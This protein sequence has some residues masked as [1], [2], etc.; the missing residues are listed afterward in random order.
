[1]SISSLFFLPHPWLSLSSSLLLSFETTAPLWVHCLL[2]NLIPHTVVAWRNWHWKSQYLPML[3]LKKT[4]FSQYLPA[5]RVKPWAKKRKQ[6]SHLLRALPKLYHRVTSFHNSTDLESICLFPVLQTTLV[7]GCLFAHSPQH[8]IYF[9]C[10]PWPLIHILPLDCTIQ[11]Y[12]QQT[13]ILTDYPSDSLTLFSLILLDILKLL[14]GQHCAK[15][16]KYSSVQG[17]HSPALR[18]CKH[19]YRHNNNF[20]KCCVKKITQYYKSI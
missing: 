15:H 12:A 8:Q 2:A 7:V 5:Q 18:K 20:L 16:W 1:M 14:N 9:F 17:E 11:F 19:T 10:S 13:T 3:S 4:I 6:L